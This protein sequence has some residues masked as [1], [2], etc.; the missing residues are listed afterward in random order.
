[1]VDT[2]KEKIYNYLRKNMNKGYSSETLKWAL[3][4]QGYSRIIVENAI[5]EINKELAKT[6]PVL[7][8]KPIIKYEILDEYNRPITIKKS[9]WRRILG[10]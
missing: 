10:L 9:W 6:A 5:E 8:E 7:K 2:Y 3:V 1:M 4:N